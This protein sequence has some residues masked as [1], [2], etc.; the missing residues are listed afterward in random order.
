MMLLTLAPHLILRQQLQLPA[1]RNV[2]RGL[3]LGD[4]DLIGELGHWRLLVQAI[5]LR[6][7]RGDTICED[8]APF[9]R[10]KLKAEALDH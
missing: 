2:L 7:R 10:E 1:D 5:L 6:R 3:V 8:D 9:K 4:D